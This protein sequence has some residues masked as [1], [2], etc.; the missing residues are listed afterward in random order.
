MVVLLGRP[1]QLKMATWQQVSYGMRRPVRNVVDELMF[2]I[3]R[4]ITA[5][6]HR[7]FHRK[8]VQWMDRWMD[9][10]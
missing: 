2:L 1:I 5:G 4:A 6:Q 3:Q 8:G 7:T 10:F 9:A